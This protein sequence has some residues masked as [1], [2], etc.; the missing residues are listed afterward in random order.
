MTGWRDLLPPDTAPVVLLHSAYFN[1]RQFDRLRELLPARECHAPSYR[2]QNGIPCGDRP[3]TMETLAEDLVRDVRHRFKVPVHLVGNSMG[4]F[5]AVH[6]CA[7]APQ[8]FR[9]LALLGA[10]AAPEPDPGRFAALENDVRLRGAAHMAGNIAKVIFGRTYFEEQ[11][12]E[13]AR[14]T[15]V[16]AN[17]D[18]AIADTMHAIY[19]RSDMRPLIAAMSAPILLLSG[20]EDGVRKPE[21]M[22]QIAI[23]W[24]GSLYCSIPKAGHTVAL[25]QP[26]AVSRLLTWWWDYLAGA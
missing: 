2:G 24:P 19:T 17:A 3:I 26:R 6:A 14:W 5:V 16:F 18:P 4:A 15:E 8:L 12:A 11:P 1:G 23:D 20:A 13:A 21:E 10:T 7:Q 22:S 25:E 9:S